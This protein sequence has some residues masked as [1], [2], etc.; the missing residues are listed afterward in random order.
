MN[1]ISNPFLSEETDF[2]YKTST[3]DGS[4]FQPD[5]FKGFS[6]DQIKYIFEENDAVLAEKRK[7]KRDADEEKKDWDQF[8]AS[9]IEEMEK[10]EIERQLRVKHDNHIQ[11][12]TLKLQREELREKQAQMKKDKFGAIGEGFFQKFGQSCR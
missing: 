6:K 8:Q 5:H 1:S 3:K 7:L 9:V 12:E 10:A 11:A 4:K 2:S